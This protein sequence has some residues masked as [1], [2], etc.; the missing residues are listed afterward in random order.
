MNV[1]IEVRVE[2]V[3]DVIMKCCVGVLYFDEE[4]VFLLIIILIIVFFFVDVLEIDRMVILWLV[5]SDDDEVSVEEDNEED[6]IEGFVV[7]DMVNSV[8]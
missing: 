7:E 6:R 1:F 3:L 2:K 8:I 5:Y 4:D